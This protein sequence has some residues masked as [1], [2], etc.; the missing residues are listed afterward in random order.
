VDR[1]PLELSVNEE[2]EEK[3][4]RADHQPAHQQR[5]A[6]YIA[7]ETHLRQVGDLDVGFATRAVLNG[8]GRN[9][10]RLRR[11]GRAFSGR[12][13]SWILSPGTL[14]EERKDERDDYRQSTKKQC[15][16]PIHS[17]FLHG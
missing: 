16:L 13:R 14:R 15:K 11:Y 9:A 4:Q 8:G 10:A 5:A 2:T 17:E 7:E 3:S 1:H 12:A 6:G